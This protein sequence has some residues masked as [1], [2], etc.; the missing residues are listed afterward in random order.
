MNC[1]I[2]ANVF[3]LCCLR[4]ELRAGPPD[5]VSWD[6]MMP[7]FTGYFVY[8]GLVQV[9]DTCNHLR[10]YY[11]TF[12]SRTLLDSHFSYL[13]TFFFVCRSSK[14]ATKRRGTMLAWPWARCVSSCDRIWQS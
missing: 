4:F 9:H 13:V 3:A 14:R 5:S 12:E 10:K 6:M 8:Q 1:A 7:H 11:R 2:W